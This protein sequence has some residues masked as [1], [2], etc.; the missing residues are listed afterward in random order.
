MNS[1]LRGVVTYFFV[2]LIFRLAGKRTLAQISTFDAVLL[3]II[4]ETTQ[5]AL[6]DNDQSL[7]NSML[8]ILTM[9]GIDILLSYV[10]EYWPAAEHVIDG[11]PIVILDH[12]G[13]D[14]RI[15]HKER[16]NEEDILHAGRQLCGVAN[17]D[18]IEY[19][20]LEQTGHITIIPK[21]KKA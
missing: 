5:A 20:I 21:R 14:Q 19:A 17:F 8:L 10:K 4:S 3:L 16:V 9:V 1:V 7:T 15:L 13:P 12:N 18:E 2:W 6:I 11:S